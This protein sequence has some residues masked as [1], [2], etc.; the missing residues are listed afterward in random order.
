MRAYISNRDWYALLELF[1]LL[2]GMA[3]ISFGAALIYL[4]AGFVVGGVL[5]LLAGIDARRE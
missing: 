5:L 2:A 3:L 4:P 1:V